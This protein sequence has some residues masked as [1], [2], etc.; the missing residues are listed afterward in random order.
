MQFKTLLAGMAACITLTASGPMELEREL[1][2]ARTIV[3]GHLESK[4]GFYGPDGEIF[5]ELSF[6]IDAGLKDGDGRAIRGLTLTLTVPGGEVG[7]VG[8]LDSTA[9]ELGAGEPVLVLLDEQLRATRGFSLGGDTVSGLEL[10]PEELVSLVGLSLV[11]EGMRIPVEEFRQAQR[12][13]EGYAAVAPLAATVSCYKLLGP[14]WLNKAATFRLDS[15]LPANYAEPMR[16][17]TA[18][19]TAAGSQFRFSEDARSANVVNLQALSQSNVLAQTRVWYQP[20]TNSITSFTLTFN[21]RQPWGVGEAG[22]FDI[23]GVG[24][25]ELGHAL[26]L[27][28]PADASCAEQTMW[29]SAGVAETKKRTLETGDKEGTVLMYAAS[30]ASPPAPAPT[31]AP[32]PTPTPTP[33]PT[34]P[35]AP[36][37]TVPTPVLSSLTIYPRATAGRTAY[38]V[39]AG[40]AFDPARIEFVIQGPGCPTAGC[41]TATSRLFNVSATQAYGGF[42]TGVAGNYTLRLRNGATGALSANA[43][44]FVVR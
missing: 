39:V 25:H 14:K 17:A 12:A 6:R 16:R 26:G 9:P 38:L 28:H 3:V 27:D 18:T 13:I 40:S 33:A 20:S 43:A 23:E 37:P 15:A 44:T 5:S 41:V 34:P 30:A 11:E 35:P 36:A 21:S 10:R 7:D 19:W 22:K 8:L 42:L 31:P 29:F 24:A 4:R 2:E 32:T 1:R